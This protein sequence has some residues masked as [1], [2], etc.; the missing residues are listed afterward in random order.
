MHIVTINGNKYG[1]ENMSAFD[2]MHFVRRLGAFISDAPEEMFRAI[3][4]MS[5]ADFEATI[6]YLLK[7]A[8][9]ADASGAGFAPLLVN[10]KLMYSDI[11]LVDLLD[12]CHEVF[13]AN[14]AD[15]LPILA[16]KLAGSKGA[17]I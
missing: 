1:I 5:D 7:Y 17:I 16:S 6:A 13:K 14:I 8:R 2:A 10:G 12:I 11:N 15:F 9:R 4:S 3:S